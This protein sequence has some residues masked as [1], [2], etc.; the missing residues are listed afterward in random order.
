MVGVTVRKRDS[1]ER[2]NTIVRIILHGIVGVGK[3]VLCKRG[4]VNGTC[5][6]ENVEGRHTL[7]ELPRM[8]DCVA[9]TRDITVRLDVSLR[10]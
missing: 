6:A 9:Y 8:L 7:A 1:V 3:T 2:S 5:F 10:S 4:P